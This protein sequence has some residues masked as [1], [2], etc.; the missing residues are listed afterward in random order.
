MGV[1]ARKECF[2]TIKD[3]KEDFP[4]SIKT[5]LINPSKPEM[6]KVSK[7]YLGDINKAIA[8]SSKVNLWRNTSTV[9]DWFTNTTNKGS[10]RFIKFDIVEFNPSISENLLDKAINYAKSI[11]TINDE[12]IAIIKN[13][14]KSLLF[15]LKEPWMKKGNNPMFDVTM[16]SYD[17]AEICE[18]VGLFLLNRLS[19]IIDK[20][21][22]GLY[23]DDGLAIVKNA[24]G[25]MLD[26]LRKKII[27]LFKSEGLSITIET[28]LTV[29]DFLD[30]TLDLQRAKFY[31][32]R[33]PNNSPDYINAGS[34]HPSTIIKELPRMINKRISDLSCDLNEF[35]KAK[36]LYESALRNNGHNIP[37][38]EYK[39]VQKNPKRSRKRS[40]TWFNPPYNIDVKTNVGKSFICLVKKHFPKEHKL[41]KIFNTN[42]LKLSYS[43]TANMARVIKQHNAKILSSSD[44]ST[45]TSRLCNCRDKGSCPLD[46][47]CLEKCIVYK[48]EVT[49]SSNNETKTYYGAC[50]GEFKTRYNNHT[51]SFRL[52][53]YISDTELSKHVWSLKDNNKDYTIKWS[54]ASHASPFRCG[55]N[56]CDLCLTE[57]LFI[58]RSD[59]KHLLN[60]R[61]ELISKCRHKNKF[62][63]C[64]V[65]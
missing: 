20:R 41:N 12:A 65:K 57:K 47:K 51:K 40:I 35:N 14:R 62:L 34:N 19:S 61:S 13:A 9:L 3:H 31:P 5:R 37:D 30:V 2:V 8:A 56:K 25:P 39:R 50:E 23:R 29:T 49:T 52:K 64:N 24:N 43:C 27:A 16:G 55:A 54:I 22:V 26:N 15:D 44:P 42:T 28:N 33:K 38:F 17:G 4:N 32:Y 45:T 1:T 53:K 10:S 36:P 11:T 21:Y 58:I 6:G 7:K 18:L 59:K 46:G 60:K 48:A 63:L